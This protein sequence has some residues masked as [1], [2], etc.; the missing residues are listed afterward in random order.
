M[1]PTPDPVFIRDEIARAAARLRDAYDDLGQAAAETQLADPS[2]LIDA[3]TDV[4]DRLALRERACDGDASTSS[5][6]GLGDLG[7]LGIHLLAQLANLARGLKLPQQ[8][9]ALE[10]L[11]LP[12]A[13][14]VARA[15]GELSF[16]GPVVNAAAGLAE[17]ARGAR[18]MIELYRMTDEV[19]CGVSP[20]V[21]EAAPTSE[22]SRTWRAL[23]VNRAIMATRT[24]QPALMEAAFDGLLE[25][26]PSDAPAF[27]RK[28][29]EQMQAPDYPANYPPRVRL[30]MQ[31]Y[32]DAWDSER[33]LH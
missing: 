31:R 11:A 14:C 15:G 30:V 1:L 16:I 21:T 28:G 23:I 10:R 17:A 12:L 22:A 6:P 32:F 3:L 26:C 24:H 33:R 25:H 19:A 4:L 13:C 5:E 2:G 8:A 29:M 7:D 18:E 9:D 20:R 27:F